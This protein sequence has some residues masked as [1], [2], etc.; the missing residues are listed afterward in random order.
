MSFKLKVLGTKAT[1]DG[2][3]VMQPL[4]VTNA[5]GVTTVWDANSEITDLQI[6]EEMA[7]ALVDA[8]QLE[9]LEGEFTQP[10]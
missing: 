7:K 4:E 2:V 3:E 6:T 1:V 5:K 8:G 9:L 10:E